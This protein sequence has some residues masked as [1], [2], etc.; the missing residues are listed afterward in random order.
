MF[1]DPLQDAYL[2]ERAYFDS[3]YFNDRRREK[4][5]I[6]EYQRILK[7]ANIGTV[8]D[9]GCGTGGFLSVF[10]DRW[11]KYGYE[12]SD[13]AETTARKKGIN[14]LHRVSDLGYDNADVVVMRGVLQ[15]INYPMQTLHQA[16]SVLK[17]GGTLAILATPDTD[18]IVYKI[19]GMLPALDAPRNWVLFGHRALVNILGRLGYEDI[20]II[21]PYWKSPYANPLMDFSKFFASLIFGYH[22]FA[23]PG[24]MLEIY[25]HKK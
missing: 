22:P 2:Y 24:N 13:F 15:H 17:K 14:M 23:F 1:S 16:T 11:D 18:S 8:L 25:A 10:D 3:H 19:W 20:E 21:Y 12:P 9:I 7:R 6:L 4:M 5:Y